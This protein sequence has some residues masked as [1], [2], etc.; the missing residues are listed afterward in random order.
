M[1]PYQGKCYFLPFLHGN[2]ALEGFFELTWRP[3]KT[4]DSPHSLL[5]ELLRNK[6][7]VTRCVVL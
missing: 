7:T 6:D 4:L 3:P 1:T 2:W 5:P